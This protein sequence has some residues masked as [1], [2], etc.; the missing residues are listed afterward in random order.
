MK[1]IIGT[2][3]FTL[4]LFT[5]L[6]AQIKS[7]VLVLFEGSG[8]H[9][10]FSKRAVVWLDSLS[11]RN[12]MSVDFLNDTKK[13]TSS[14]LAKYRLI[15]QLDYPPYGW[16]AEATKA[17][18][19]YILQGRGGYLGLH[20]ATLIGD[21]DGYK[22]WPWFRKFM[23]EIT[24]KSYIPNFA[25]AKVVVEKPD[26]PIFLGLKENFFINKEEWYTYDK[27]PRG[28]VEV[29]ARVDEDSYFPSSATKMGDHPVIW[30][31]NNVKARNIYIFMGHG[32]DLFD[33]ADYK[34][35]LENSIRWTLG[36][37]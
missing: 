25:S 11:E 21:F 37:Y 27:S 16:S 4:L 32:A 24:F 33:N 13:F 15:I 5:Q 10:G 36:S 28:N 17:F 30:S 20:H 2:L 12:G 34:R 23:G 7:G 19:D 22:P 35:L 1:K 26:H 3:I 29:L 18:K 31:N 6:Q 9:L 14:F 8:H